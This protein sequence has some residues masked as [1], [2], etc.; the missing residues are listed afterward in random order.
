MEL[1]PVWQQQKLLQFCAEKGIK[2]T[3]YSPLGGQ[4]AGAPNPVMESEVL[5]E[6]AKAK[7]KTVAQVI[8]NALIGNLRVLV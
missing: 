1:N 6:I 5:K 2:V 7:G 4:S 8:F 3:A